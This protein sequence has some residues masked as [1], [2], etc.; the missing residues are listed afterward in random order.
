VQAWP[1]YTDGGHAL[2]KK[3]PKK[4]N[5]PLPKSDRLLGEDDS[6]HRA[7]DR[8]PLFRGKLSEIQILIQ[9]RATPEARPTA[10]IK[11]V[12]GALECA[13]VGGTATTAV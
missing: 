13:D 3:L 1:I 6:H 8:S 2:K 7:S 12:E 11:G 10:D 9:I 5:K 4:Q